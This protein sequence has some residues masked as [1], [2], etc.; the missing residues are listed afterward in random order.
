VVP[1]SHTGPIVEHVTYPDSIHAE[2]PRE[3][4]RDLRVDHVEL[5]PGDCVLWHSHLWHSS[6]PNRSDRDRIGVGGVWVEPGM[7][8][9]LTGVGRLRWAMCGG[10]VLAHPAPELIVAQDVEPAAV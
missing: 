10:E 2:L 5:E 4:C 1:G 7:I 6:P 8:G 3:R 9:E